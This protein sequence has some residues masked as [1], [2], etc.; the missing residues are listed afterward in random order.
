VPDQQKFDEIFDVITIDSVIKEVKDEQARKYIESGLD[1]QLQVKSVENYI[2]KQ[3][4][5]FVQNFAKDTGDYRSLSLVD[6]LVIALGVRLSRDR[7]DFEKLRSEPKPLTEFKP[8]SMQPEFDLDESSEYDSEGSK[9]EPE[10]AEDD[11]WN[12]VAE[13][14]Q[15]K[16]TKK[17]E[18]EKAEHYERKKMQKE[19]EQSL[20]EE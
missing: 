1:F 19:F 20:V 12:E 2:Q 15:T 17:R 8:L 6:Q 7:D 10:E 3:D 4:L 5:T 18:Q 14:R 9:S 13:D 11:G 16:R